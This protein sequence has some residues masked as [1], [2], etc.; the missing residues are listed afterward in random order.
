M[1]TTSGLFPCDSVP[2][3]TTLMCSGP[4]M[5]GKRE[6][7]L[8]FLAQGAADG[9]VAVF[10]STDAGADK[11]RR[12]YARHSD[13]PDQL[14]VVDCT[15]EPDSG[16]ADDWTHYVSSP[17]DLTGI[18]VGVSTLLSELATDGTATGIRVCLSSLTSLFL[19]AEAERVG[20][21]LH[22]LVGRLAT[23]N[24]LGLFAVQTDTLGDEAFGQVQ[25]LVDGELALRDGENGTEA[26]IR[27][28]SDVGEEWQPVP[29]W[30]PEP[31]G[32]GTTAESEGTTEPESVPVSLKA[33]IDDVA[34]ERP[35]LTVYNYDG[36][37]TRL[38][39]LESHCETIN[40]AFRET[41]LREDTPH[42][43][44][45]LHRG[46]DLIGAEPVQSLLASFEAVEGDIEAPETDAR[47]LLTDLSRSTFGARGADWAFLVDISHVIEME[48]WRAGSGTLHAGFQRLSNLWGDDEARRVYRRLA[49]S[50][51]EVHVYGAPDTDPEEWD[52]VTTH[53]TTNEEIGT[54][55]F[56]V[57]DGGGDPEG[58][59][60]LLVQKSGPGTYDGFWTYRADLTDRI[61]NYVA[62]RYATPNGKH[63][64]GL[65]VT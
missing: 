15:G 14:A 12:E 64:S 54:S 37:P 5:V 59:A 63:H 31:V 25:T 56:V 2:G 62:E 10:V 30:S 16:A 9:E 36:D 40:V 43:V 24:A 34:T 26:R 42:N 7:C 18:G 27:G 60:A 6:F 13:H 8:R 53:P 39:A 35:Q 44:A 19:Y 48:A 28:L 46:S 45:M 51:V 3:G 55:W 17:A 49:E 41:T 38:A 11:I 50:G 21:F 29:D 23:A 1:Y 57:Y 32:V 52:G 22:V 4:P 20:Q 58:R 33:V 61:A 47:A 65:Q